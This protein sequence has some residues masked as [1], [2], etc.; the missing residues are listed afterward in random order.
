MPTL[1]MN[2]YMQ[3]EEIGHGS[4]G[5]LVKAVDS[6]NPTKVVAIKIVTNQ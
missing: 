6:Q 2:R 4:F 3:E 1:I 5:K